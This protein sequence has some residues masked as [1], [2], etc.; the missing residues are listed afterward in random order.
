MTTT[1]PT[2]AVGHSAG[3]AMQV[4]TVA[5]HAAL[6][7]RRQSERRIARAP[8]LVTVRNLKMHFPVTEGAL[9]P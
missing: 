2:N 1:R 4:S 7:Q 5:E 9:I 6:E 8:D 3:A